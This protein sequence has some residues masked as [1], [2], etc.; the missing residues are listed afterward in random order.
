MISSIIAASNHITI[1]INGNNTYIGNLGQFSGQLK[2][3]T[4]SQLIEIYDGMQWIPINQSHVSIDISPEIK[5]IIEWAKIQMH[6][7]S[8][9]KTMAENN[10]AIKL[11]YEN[12]KNA[13]QNLLIT[14]LLS[15]NNQNS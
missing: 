7:E 13:E 12:Y 4:T 5:Q 10:P 15:N 9:I 11:A 6:K 8:H 1:N 3:N 2:Y 14:T